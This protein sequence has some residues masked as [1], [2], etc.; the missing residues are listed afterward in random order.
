MTTK[1]TL[2]EV[3]NY[4]SA[5]TRKVSMA[6]MKELTPEDREELCI[7]VGKELNK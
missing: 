2:S 6:E 5:G 4:F 3:R 1:A 7:L